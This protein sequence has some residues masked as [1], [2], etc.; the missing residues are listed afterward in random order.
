V[1]AG[2]VLEGKTM[3]FIKKLTTIGARARAPY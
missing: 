2:E 1:P 3:V